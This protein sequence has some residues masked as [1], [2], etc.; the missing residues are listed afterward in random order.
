MA[1]AI[2]YGLIGALI[3]VAGTAAIVNLPSN[4]SAADKE[5]AQRIEDTFDRNNKAAA[6]ALAKSPYAKMN[7]QQ[8]CDLPIAKPMLD[9]KEG[10]KFIIRSRECDGGSARVS[11]YIKFDSFAGEATVKA[12]SPIA[13]PPQYRHTTVLPAPAM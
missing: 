11:F 10:D 3:V 9:H 7:W 5:A 12:D 2:E 4:K 13:L 1:T 6:A 8:L